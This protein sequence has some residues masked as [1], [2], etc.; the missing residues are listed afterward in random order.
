MPR[1]LTAAFQTHV[2]GG[3]QTIATLWKLTTKAA[4][5]YGYTSHV[6]D[7]VVDSV[8]YTS[9]QGMTPTSIKISLSTGIDNLSIQCLFTN[10]GITEAALRAGTLD[11]ATLVM[12]LCNYRDV[13]SGAGCTMFAGRLGN[14]TIRNGE[15]EAE[16]RGLMQH[17]R[18][19]LGWITSPV[20]RWDFGGT[21]CGFT[22]ATDTG[23]VA[24]RTS[25]R[26]FDGTGITGAGD[27]FYAYGII[28]FTSGLNNGLRMEVKKYTSVSGALEL[29]QPMPFTVANGDT[30]T[31]EEGCD[32]LWSTCKT[33]TNEERF[34][35]EPH[36]PGMDAVLRRPPN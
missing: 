18:Q 28:E 1:T 12:F 7:L 31:I 16:C 20:C 32:G 11:G 17:A 13:A 10:A 36:V 23:T 8:P 33:K 25:D 34:G 3:V 26:V 29:A 6:A 24:N 21:E 4:V 9:A 2:E 5:V 15:W 19:P 27:G 22:P 30:F 14:V 35:G